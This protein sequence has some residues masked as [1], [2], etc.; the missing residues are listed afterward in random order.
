M[1]ALINWC[2]QL[3][4]FRTNP[5]QLPHSYPLLAV[6]FVISVF[7]F[8]LSLVGYVAWSVAVMVASYVV[9][10]QM[11]LVY[12]VLAAADK[13]ERYLKTI[14]AMLLVSLLFQF[15]ALPAMLLVYQLENAAPLL[16]ISV[17]AVIMFIQVWLM[18][19]HAYVLN[20]AL[21]VGQLM[22]FIIIIAISFVQFKFLGL[23]V[24]L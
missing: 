7:V 24:S 12:I 2:W 11:F 3:T 14:T 5:N 19:V 20:C 23:L 18:F 16:I 22:A 1:G 9:V 13:S 21:E 15:A 4:L 6:L 8:I 17:E 10:S